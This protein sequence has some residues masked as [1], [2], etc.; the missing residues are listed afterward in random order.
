VDKNSNLENGVRVQMEEFNLLVI[1]ESI[2]EVTGREARS[3]LEKGREHH[4]LD[5]TGCGNI[6]PTSRMPL[7]DYT[8]WGKVI[9]DELADFTFVYDG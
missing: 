8:V 2:E 4:S 6:F 5:R 7:Q 3:T 9:H 1:K